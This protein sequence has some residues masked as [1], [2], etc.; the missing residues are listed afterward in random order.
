MRG[1]YADESQ[2]MQL[3]DEERV[4]LRASISH[5]YVAPPFFKMAQNLDLRCVLISDPSTLGAGAK[6]RLESRIK[7]FTLLCIAGAMEKEEQSKRA[8]W[9][10]AWNHGFSRLDQMNPIAAQGKRAQLLEMRKQEIARRTK[11]DSAWDKREVK[12]LMSR[13]DASREFDE[14]LRQQM[15]REER[16]R[17]AYQKEEREARKYVTVGRVSNMAKSFASP[18]KDAKKGRSGKRPY[19]MTWQ[20]VKRAEEESVSSHVCCRVYYYVSY[21]LLYIYIHFCS[22]VCRC[23][24]DATKARDRMNPVSFTSY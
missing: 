19:V 5:S 12:M 15:K 8:K 16:E 7:K 9:D 13:P 17:T 4:K 23:T 21:M 22:S 6:T 1:R 14:Y 11:Y 24:V 2:Q 3:P 10:M 18:D 20:R